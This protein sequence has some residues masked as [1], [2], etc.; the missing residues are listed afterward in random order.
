MMRGCKAICAIL[1]PVALAGLGLAITGCGSID[2]APRV[3]HVGFLA[4]APSPAFVD[5]LREGL[6]ELGY[7]EGE[8]IN[9]EWRVTDNP[10]DLDDV[11]AELVDLGV[12]LIIAGGTQA[13]L[14][15]REKT[16]TIP[17]VMTNSGDAV[18]AG[19]VASLA[20]PGGTVTGLT[21]IA[22]L[23]SAKRVELLK[24]AVP[25]LS[26]IGVLWYPDHP[27]T[28]RSFAQIEAA[29]PQLGLEV[30]SLEVRTLEDFEEAFEISSKEGVGALI[31]LRDPFTLKH[32]KRIAE[33]AEAN[34]LPIMYETKEYLEAGGLMVYGPSFTDMYRR[35]A[36]YVDQ[37]LKG[38]SPENIP[39][40]QPTRFELVI[41]QRAADAIL[42]TFP[43]SI[44]R[45][46]DEVIR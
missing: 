7:I 14:A 41:N 30:Q 46:V 27:T 34:R 8:T 23:L 35:S 29:A 42:L 36:T 40:E 11:A 24:E 3:P 16:Y 43:E 17:I 12:D 4:V 19:L 33:L 1:M 10:D 5:A 2:E 26:R 31:I 25:D 32:R 9:I 21:Q 39:V 37:I 6:Y 28:P 44:L 15:S 20:R 13:V 38:T 22:P 18:G 45:R